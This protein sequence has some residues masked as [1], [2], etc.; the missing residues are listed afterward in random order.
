MD[1]INNLKKGKE[2]MKIITNWFEGA[3]KNK[4]KQIV[5]KKFVRKEGICQVE[6]RETKTQNVEFYLP[7][8][9]TNRFFSSYCSM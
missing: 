9:E 4:N 1:L 7:P 6:E 3:Q 2:Q 5:K 8:E